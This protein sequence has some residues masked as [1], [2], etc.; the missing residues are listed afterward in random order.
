MNIEKYLP[1]LK[2][3]RL[4][5]DINDN[6]IIYIIKIL[7]GK[8]K[9]YKSESYI[10][11]YGDKL[12]CLHLLVEGDIILVNDDV[13]GNHNILT[14]VKPGECF[15]IS[16]TLSDGEN[17]LYDA[18]TKHGCKILTLDKN[19]I[20]HPFTE[21]YNLQEQ[22]VKN[23]IKILVNRN[24]TSTEKV[25]FL[26]QRKTR[27]KILTYL[28]FVSQTQNSADFFVPYSRQ[29]LAEYLCV[30]RSALSNELCKLRDE[31]LIEFHKNHFIIKTPYNF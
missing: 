20:M 24:L 1:L 15:G 14:K 21:N 3:T 30:D 18:I 6:D 10:Y 9:E 25:L 4:F 7:K 29:Q 16:H 5:S 11:S 27:D 19:S 22:L 26:S 8:F 28:S 31:G 17:V 13:W 23:I 2:T 12:K